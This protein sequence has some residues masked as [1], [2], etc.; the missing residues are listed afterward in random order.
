MTDGD[1]G[2]TQTS[3]ALS[4]WIPAAL[5]IER[6]TSII[7]YWTKY[8]TNGALTCSQNQRQWNVERGGLTTQCVLLNRLFAAFI[9]ERRF[10]LRSRP[11][12]SHNPKESRQE[13]ET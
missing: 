11:P 7:K 10:F 4:A 2:Q 6:N 9:P 12:A 3:G 8:C 5:G 13:R 1:L